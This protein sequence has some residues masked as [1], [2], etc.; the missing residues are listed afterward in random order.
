[1]LDNVF[2]PDQPAKNEES[3]QMATLGQ[4]VTNRGWTLV[5]EGSSTPT[6]KYFKALSS[7]GT[8]A[9]GNR[10]LVA[11]LSGTYVILGKVTV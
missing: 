6:Q 2:V 10:V 5:L 3:L 9:S 1:M 8:L 7:A 4:H 11:K